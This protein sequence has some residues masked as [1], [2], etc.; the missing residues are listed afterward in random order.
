MIGSLALGGIHGYGITSAV[1]VP[2]ISIGLIVA[3]VIVLLLAFL[4]LVGTLKELKVLLGIFFAI[5][6]LLTVA[7][8]ALGMAAYTVMDLRFV[9]DEVTKIWPKASSTVHSLVQKNFVC[10]GLYGVPDTSSPCPPLGVAHGCLVPLSS[11]LNS[12]M[13][14]INVVAIIS[15][16]IQVV[17][18]IFTFLLYKATKS[19]QHEESVPLLAH[20][21]IIYVQ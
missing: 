14:T 17:I 2:Q 9:S 3:G 1:E 8:L 10:C 19:R 5:L 4:G 7:E 12:K 21:R 6:L 13:D 15:A 18:L 16:I 11:W 20:T